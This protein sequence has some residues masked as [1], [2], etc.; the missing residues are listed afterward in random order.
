M[1]A[2][3][4]PQGDLSHPQ[5]KHFRTRAHSNVLNAN[6]FWFPA[7]PAEVPVA[8]YYPDRPTSMLAIV[9]VPNFGR[10]GSLRALLR[11]AI[12]R[13]RRSHRADRRRC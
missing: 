5:K 12:E 7:T 6:D 9:S 1:M 3:S 4:Q 11:V 8:E 10:Y 2:G 13:K